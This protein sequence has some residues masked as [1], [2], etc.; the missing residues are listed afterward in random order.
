MYIGVCC[1]C[2]CY[3]K[4]RDEKQLQEQNKQTGSESDSSLITIYAGLKEPQFE[5][6]N[7]SLLLL[8]VMQPAYSLDIGREEFLLYQRTVK[9]RPFEQEL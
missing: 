8:R 9:Y 4:R 6:R 2:Y 5:V 7:H 1:K 3:W